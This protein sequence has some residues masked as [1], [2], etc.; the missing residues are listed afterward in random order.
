[1]V[2][3]KRTF[4]ITKPPSFGILLWIIFIFKTANSE[5]GCNSRAVFVTLSVVIVSSLCLTYVFLY[6][7]SAISYAC[8]RDRGYYLNRNLFIVNKEQINISSVSE[9]FAQVQATP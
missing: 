2:F 7:T 6:M 5:N 1:M 3:Y 4:P 9:P 8:N